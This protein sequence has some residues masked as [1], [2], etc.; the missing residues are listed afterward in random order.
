MEE[1]LKRL[2]K[3]PAFDL[4]VDG[5]IE[6]VTRLLGAIRL[7][8]N[9]YYPALNAIYR[10]YRHLSGAD[11]ISNFYD[12]FLNFFDYKGAIPIA[13]R[14]VDLLKSHINN[15]QQ[16][17]FEYRYILQET[18][19]LL[20]DLY[21]CLETIIKEKNIP[22]PT[23]KLQIETSKFLISIATAFSFNLL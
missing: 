10:D 6:D 19:F 14:Y 11:R 4:E 3:Y 5:A 17:E 15:T 1:N 9:D 7:L 21:D 16:L 12:S 2:R 23:Q 8:I 18:A 22:S 20:N 13:R